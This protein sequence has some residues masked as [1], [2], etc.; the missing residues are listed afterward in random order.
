MSDD[1]TDAQVLMGP[2]Y[3]A[4]RRQLI[5]LRANEIAQRFARVP[6]SRPPIPALRGKFTDLYHL[7]MTQG[8]WVDLRSGSF[9]LGPAAAVAG[10]LA[11]AGVIGLALVSF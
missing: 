10:V 8:G 1:L 7:R 6:V 5:D 2:A 11:I 4:A 9:N 3:T